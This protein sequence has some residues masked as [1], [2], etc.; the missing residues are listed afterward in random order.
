MVHV[1]NMLDYLQLWPKTGEDAEDDEEAEAALAQMVR[2]TIIQA[3]QEKGIEDPSELCAKLCEKEDQSAPHTMSTF[4]A[5][6]AAICL[7]SRI[8]VI[9]TT[10]SYGWV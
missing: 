2:Q 7:D 4:A 10:G 6:L 5:A 1:A 3:A 9:V 8:L